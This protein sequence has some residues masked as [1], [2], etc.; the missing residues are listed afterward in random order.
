MPAAA[1]RLCAVGFDLD[2]TLIDTMPDLAA[3]VNLMLRVLG[4]TELPEQ[5][6]RALV[7]QGVEKLVSRAL[8]ESLGGHS[9]HAEQTSAALELFRRLYSQ[10]LFARS[11]VYAGVE[12]LLERLRRSGMQLCCV[13]NKESA[14]ALPLLEQAGLARYLAFTLCADREE[15]RKPS[16]RLLLGA[17]ARLAIRPAQMLYVGDSRVDVEAGRAAG[18]PIAVVSYGYGALPSLRELQPDDIVGNLN[19]LALLRNAAPAPLA[20]LPSAAI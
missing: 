4:A 11:R 18:C 20:E 8:T 17:C 1:E 12:T 3:A 7:G 2:G 9:P 6:I 14:L 15:D 19:D 5:R 16:P 10:A 13:T